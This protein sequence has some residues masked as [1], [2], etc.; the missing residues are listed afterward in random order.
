MTPESDACRQTP[1]S[2]LSAIEEMGRAII[3]GRHWY[4]ALLEAIGQWQS[5][6]EY[7]QGYLYSYVI[8][9]EAFD[10]LLLAGRICSETEDLIPE[11]E[12]EALFFS[13]I[14]PIELSVTEF[15]NLIGFKKYQQYL[16]YFYGID[17][18]AALVQ[19][20]REEVRKER[21]AMGLHKDRDSD[22]EVYQRIYGLGLMDLLGLFRRQSGT[23]NVRS[24]NLTQMKEFT[25][26]LFK[27]RLRQCDP[28]RVASDTRKALNWLNLISSSRRLLSR[29]HSPEL[30]FITP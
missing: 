8:A 22:E 10:W 24:L 28:A 11:P 25:Y 4:I 9:G 29:T 30:S 23:R 12:K 20:V 19:V 7:L 26:W 3:C 18:E 21:W 2:D 27:Y 17:V 6:R 15:K 16:N 13:G 1:V 5:T 14:S